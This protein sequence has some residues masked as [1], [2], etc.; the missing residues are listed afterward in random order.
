M[1]LFGLGGPEEGAALI[2]GCT[3]LSEIPG[4]KIINSL[5][6]IE[7]TKKGVAGDAP[8]VTR[9]IFQSLLAAA[10]EQGAN[11]VV[12][13]RVVAGSYQQQGSQWEVSYLIAYGD[14]IIFE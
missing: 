4:R 6:L 11:G 5:G 8:R 3:T 2:E 12:N 1:S 14:A 7:Y 9:G 10:Q 13:V